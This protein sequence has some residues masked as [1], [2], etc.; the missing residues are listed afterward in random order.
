MKLKL[1][2]ITWVHIHAKF[3]ELLNMSAVTTETSFKQG[4][5]LHQ[6]FQL[7]GPIKLVKILEPYIHIILED[8]NFSLP[9]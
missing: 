2:H 1:E 7:F 4:G 9:R 5:K 3:K 8:V 6:D